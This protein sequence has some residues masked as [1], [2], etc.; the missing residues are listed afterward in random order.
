MLFLTA[1]MSTIATLIMGYLFYGHFFKDLVKDIPRHK[2]FR[3]IISLLAIYITCLSFAILYLNVTFATGVPSG[4]RG[5]YLGLF[6]SVSFFAIPL[7]IDSTY[8]R[9]KSTHVWLV[10]TNWIASFAIV[11]LTTGL[12]LG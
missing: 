6:T 4:L 1:L 2:P 12:M 11:G 8:L 5:L 9:A 3:L 7:Y 10:L